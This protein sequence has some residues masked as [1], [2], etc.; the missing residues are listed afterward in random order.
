MP[1]YIYYEQE[2]IERKRDAHISGN[3]TVTA[4]VKYINNPNIRV[5]VII[6]DRNAQ[7]AHIAPNNTCIIAS[8]TVERKQMVSE[9]ENN[10]KPGAIYNNTA[11]LTISKGSQILFRR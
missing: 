5:D 1:G 7:V 2:V 4:G 10:M 8:N 6:V 9:Q 11:K 3:G